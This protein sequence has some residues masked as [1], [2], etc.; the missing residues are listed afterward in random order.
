[1]KILAIIPARAHST[2]LLNKNLCK[3]KNK[4]L[5]EITISLAKKITYIDDILVTSNSNKINTIAKNKNVKFVNNRPIGISMKSTSSAVTIIHAVKWYEKKF[6]KIDVIVLLQPTSPFRNVKFVNY[7]FEKFFKFKKT[8]ISVTRKKNNLLSSD[9]SIYI[10]KK[11]K[12]FKLK[13]FME[14]LS[15]KVISRNKKNNLD[16]DN[17]KDLERANFLSNLNKI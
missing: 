17:F 12:L 14:K 4:T 8:V 3:I 16:I 5:I 15:L 1:M 9:G 10:I 6:Q 7:C 2:R 13:H 11:E